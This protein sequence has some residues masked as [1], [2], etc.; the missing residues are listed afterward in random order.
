LRDEADGRS[1]VGNDLYFGLG[2]VLVFSIIAVIF[3]VLNV[4]ILSRLLRPKRPE[5]EKET[6]YECGEPPAGSSW[7]RFDMRF[8]SVALVFLIFDVEVAVIYPWAL[9]YKRLA[10]YGGAFIFAEMF[11]FILVV[12]VGLV[13]AWAKGDLEWVKSISTEEARAGKRAGSRAPGA[14][15]ATPLAPAVAEKV[16]S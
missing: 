15:P 2:N 9:V 13:Y 12:G 7:V 6:T 8:Y 11:F 3:V 14:P 1:A 10:E 16:A 4:A 5:P